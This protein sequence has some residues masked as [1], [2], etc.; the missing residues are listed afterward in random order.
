MT[1]WSSFF[2]SCSHVNTT[3]IFNNTCTFAATSMILHGLNKGGK[4]NPSFSRPMHWVFD[5]NA[6]KKNWSLQIKLW[7]HF[8]IGHLA[9]GTT[10]DGHWTLC[11]II[12]TH[13]QQNR[14]KPMFC[15]TSNDWDSERK[16][17]ELTMKNPTVKK[18]RAVRCQPWFPNVV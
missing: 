18:N 3:K 16:K 15:W 17:E 9:V 13:L 11:P 7:I 2:P 8:N 10:I 1:H 12:S 14:I 4:N 5:F 6:K